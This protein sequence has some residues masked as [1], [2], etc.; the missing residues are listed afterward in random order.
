MNSKVASHIIHI[1]RSGRPHS[2]RLK[3][4]IIQDKP[5]SYRVEKV[6]DIQNIPIPKCEF[7]GMMS[8]L[9]RHI[10]SL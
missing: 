1:V 3:P 7:K 9:A 10:K 4:S 2:L 6:P 5:H 8:W